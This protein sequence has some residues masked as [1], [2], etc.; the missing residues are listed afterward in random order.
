VTDFPTR[1]KGIEHLKTQLDF[2]NQTLTTAYNDIIDR[3]IIC[4]TERPQT[5]ILWCE[6]IPTPNAKNQLRHLS[7]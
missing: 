2:K 3:H 6:S 5:L 4:Q 1:F 7:R